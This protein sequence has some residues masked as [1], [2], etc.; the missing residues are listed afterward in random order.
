MAGFRQ[1]LR[2]SGA[3]P[4]GLAQGQV[5]RI[6]N[7]AV[8]LDIDMHRSR[9]PTAKQRW[10]VIVDSNDRCRDTT[11][12]TALIVPLTAS[13]DLKYPTSLPLSASKAPFLQRDSVA[14][15]HLV[16]PVARRYLSGDRYMGQLDDDDIADLLTMLARTLGIIEQPQ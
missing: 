11:L 8:R 12:L 2:N 14:L 7:Q 1:A 15:T 13:V 4:T 10:V 5:W 3:H 6:D 9:Q 16:Q